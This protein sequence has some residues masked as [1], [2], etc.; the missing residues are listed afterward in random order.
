MLSP[1]NSC[2]TPS[3]TS[4]ICAVDHGVI[5]PLP[6]SRPFLLFTWHPFRRVTL[7]E[8]PNFFPFTS[9]R[10]I[11]TALSIACLHERVALVSPVIRWPGKTWIGVGEGGF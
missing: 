8:F 6:T 2:H 3:P 11:A 10:T 5:I 9:Q 1:V 4:S 7:R